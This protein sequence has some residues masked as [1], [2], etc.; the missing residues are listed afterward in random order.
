MSMQLKTPGVY[1]QATS[2]E[3]DAILALPTA[4]PAFVGFTESASQGGRT[5]VATPVRITSMAQFQDTFADPDGAT[6]G[7]PRPRFDYAADT[8]AV[9]PLRAAADAPR[10]NLYYSLQ[11]FF[12][13]GGGAC[14]IVSIGTYAD[15]L[16]NGG[17]PDAQAFLAGLAAI[18]QDEGTTMIVVPDAVMLD[19]QGWAAVSCAALRQCGARRDRVALLDVREGWR[20]PD[21]G[22][23]DPVTGSAGLRALLGAAGAERRYG[24]AYYP[25][26]NTTVVGPGAIDF[27]WLSAPTLPTLQAGLRA[28][29]AQLFPPRRDG[30]PDPKHAP[31]TAIVDGLAAAR[32]DAVRTSHQAL[33]AH[34]PLYRQAMA[35]VAASVNL[36]PPAGAMAGV[37]VRNDTT[38]G[39]NHA[40]ANTTIISALAPAVRI[41]DAAQ[42]TL[43]APLDGLAVNAIRTFPGHGVLVWGARTLDANSQDWR[44][45]SVLRTTIMLERSIA[46]F[47]GTCALRANDAHTWAHVRDT[48]GRFLAAQWAAG[49]LA[50]ARAADAW[51]VRVGIGA[52]MTGMDVLDGVMKVS[53]DVA[54][55][56][57]DEFIEL[58]FVQEMQAARGLPG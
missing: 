6:R 31:Y 21:G 11:L 25:W 8:S 27:S 24:M 15:V 35:D 44:Y 57:P 32:G 46:A 33:L 5:L 45:I 16:A 36:L 19:A 30:T 54:V 18:G 1:V 37:F 42:A 23:D 52:T 10:F 55:A 3:P 28:E 7:A 40:P 38:F 9:P 53:V 26:L 29:A 39:V 56:R 20:A 2:D 17:P 58:T 51:R 22:P 41:D 4:I 13:N 12:D 48:I 43:N 47:L 49:V 34:S 50:G 14:N